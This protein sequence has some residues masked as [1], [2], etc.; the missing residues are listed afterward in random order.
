MTP[1]DKL[2]WTKIVLI[3]VGIPFGIPL[4]LGLLMWIMH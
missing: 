4:V 3:F 1:E 2:W